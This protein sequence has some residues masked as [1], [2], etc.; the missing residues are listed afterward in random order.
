MK[1]VGEVTFPPANA[2]GSE[3]CVHR[4]GKSQNRWNL[5]VRRGRL[6]TE[7]LILLQGFLLLQEPGQHQA[8]RVSVV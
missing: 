1:I 3:R 8:Q 2:G 4:I 5:Y 6:P 7:L